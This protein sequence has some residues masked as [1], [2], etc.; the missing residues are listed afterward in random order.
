MLERT[1]ARDAEVRYLATLLRLKDSCVAFGHAFL[2]ASIAA[3]HVSAEVPAAAETQTALVETLRAL[4]E[5]LPGA[6]EVFKQV[7]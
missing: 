3:R 2:E 4:A 5:H 6:R 7:I 1:D